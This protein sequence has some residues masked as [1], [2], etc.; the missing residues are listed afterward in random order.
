MTNAVTFF[1]TEFE[2]IFHI[3]VKLAFDM[4]QETVSF[5]SLATPLKY[6]K[7]SQ[8]KRI[9]F[10]VRKLTLLETETMIFMVDG[11]PV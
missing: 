10:F 5:H 7:I 6:D 4:Y 3:S 2:R 9:L 8:K 11:N 1:F